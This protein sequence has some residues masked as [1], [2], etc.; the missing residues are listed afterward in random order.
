MALTNK[1]I[2]FPFLFTIFPIILLYSDNIDEVP[3]TDLFTPLI[4]TFLIIFPLFAV[5]NYILKSGIKSGIILTLLAAIF[6]SYGHIFNMLQDTPLFYLDL[7]HQKYV[8]IPFMIVLITGVYF[9]VK[10]KKDLT[11]F[12]SIFNVVSIVMIFFVFFNIGGF[13]L[14]NNSDID[15]LDENSFGNKLDE[16][17]FGNKPTL[18]N[19]F[20]D[21][22]HIVLDE[23]TRDDVLLEDFQFDNSEFLNYLVNSNFSIPSNPL[24]N[25]PATEPFLSSLM[26]MQYLNKINLEKYDR[27]ETERIISDNFVMKF[28][29][30]QGYKVIVPYSGYGTPDRYLESDENPCSDVIFL[31]NRFLTELSRTT[32]LNYFVEK[33]IENERRYIQLCT[34]SELPDIGKKYDAPVYVFTHLFIPH[35][36]YL[37]DKD[38]NAVTPQTSKLKGLQG[39]NNAN[40][41]LNE[42]Q[43]INKKMMNIMTKILSE[44]DESIIIIQGD[45]GSSILNNPD[46]SDYMKKRLSILYAIHIP[47]ADAKSFSKNISSVNTYRIIFNNYFE[48][49]LEILD[50][51]YYWYTDSDAIDDNHFKDITEIMN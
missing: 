45:T 26:N 47:N 6:F 50:N 41:Y 43:F 7:V 18:G 13:Y 33:Q 44:S 30:Q 1:L 51:R 48:T 35:A 22:Y 29:K 4:L 12:R 49:N 19:A 9:L 36:P 23:Y 37:F 25:Y 17:S 2:I 46:I 27:L 34:L 5:L 14:G 3:V 16:N 20:P 21:I 8:I 28:L 39:W 15:G 40:G 31:K 42:I 24:S 11:N 32:V 38:G 10:T